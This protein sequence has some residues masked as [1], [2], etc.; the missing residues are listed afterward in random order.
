MRVALNWWLSAGG[1]F[2]AIGFLAA[3]DFFQGFE[4]RSQF[5]DFRSAANAWPGAT[6][7]KNTL[8]MRALGRESRKDNHLN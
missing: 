5:G 6:G 7:E 8:Q 2:R 1:S 3:L 4:A